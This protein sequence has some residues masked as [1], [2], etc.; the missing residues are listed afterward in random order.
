MGI[1][2]PAHSWV[3]VAD[4]NYIAIRSLYAQR[5]WWSFAILAAHAFELYLKAYLVKVT[6]HYSNIHQIEKLCQQAAEHDQFF[7]DLLAEPNFERSWGSYFSYLRYPE[8]L[9]NQVR[10]PGAAC[11]ATV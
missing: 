9:P 6:G 7:G 10:P 3:Y 4:N 1:K 11:W 8:P 5:L 2:S